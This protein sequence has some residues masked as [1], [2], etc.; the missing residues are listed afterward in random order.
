MAVKYNSNAVRHICKDGTYARELKYGGSVVWEETYGTYQPGTLP[1]GVASLTCTRTSTSEPT[2]Y[3]GTLASGATLY[4][5]DKL[6]FAATANAYWTVSMT[7][8][9]L[10]VT[11][12]ASSAESTFYGASKTGVSATR[13][14]RKVTILV[15]TGVASI[16][17]T[18]TSSS[19]ATTSKTVTVVG[20]TD[21][22]A[23]CG[24]TI[25]WTATAASGYTVSPS[26]GTIAAGTA[27]VTISPTATSSM[28][29]ME[30]CS[31]Y[32]GS[33]L[34][35]SISTW[36]RSGTSGTGECTTWGLGGM[37]KY[38]KVMV[39]G[40]YAVT[41]SISGVTDSGSFS[42]VVL[43][44]DG[45]IT[46]L[47]AYSLYKSNSTKIYGSCSGTLYMQLTDQLKASSS[48]TRSGTLTLVPSAISITIT[49]VQVYVRYDGDDDSVLEVGY[50][51]YGI[52]TYPYFT[53]DVY[54]LGDIEWT[55]TSNSSTSFEKVGT[56]KDTDD[57]LSIYAET[58]G[59][60]QEHMESA[61]CYIALADEGG[62]YLISTMHHFEM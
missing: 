49:S 8:P 6:S 24:G 37:S 23:Y 55:S 9:S 25:S 1:T 58:F 54:V 45:S 15:F 5:N 46:K 33:G 32:L 17:V 29:W 11:S 42:N 50:S 12:N 18:Y 27:A 13:Q 30:V 39:S 61:D 51:D 7:Y 14:V 52:I 28:S 19:G 40:T 31:D 4:N 3:T 22:Y 47:G 35:S 48:Y 38:E 53:S 10:T 57:H 21:V 56:Y 62:T 44:S 34:T 60:D 26:S 43:N 59:G 36:T 16:T 41:G 2:S 20:G